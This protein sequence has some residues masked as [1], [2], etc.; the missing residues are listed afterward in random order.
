MQRETE[1]PRAWD[2]AFIGV[3][4]EAKI[5]WA[6]SLLFIGEFKTSEQEFKE[7]REKTSSLND[8]SLKSTKVSKTKW[9]WGGRS[10]LALY[11]VG[12]LT[13]CLF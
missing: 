5:S 6:Y 13:I 1:R 9:G 3:E 10:I 4:G 7:R 8:Q 2:S 11:L 12:W